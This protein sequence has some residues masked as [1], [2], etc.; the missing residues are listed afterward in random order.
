MV[1]GLWE[2]MAKD[3]AMPLPRSIVNTGHEWLLHLLDT[4]GEGERLPLL[5]TLWRAWHVRNEVVHFKPAPPI[6]ASWRF[7]GSY[8]NSL[9][10][11][12]QHPLAD[13]A[14]GKMVVSYGR[15]SQLHSWKAAP[16]GRS[17][18]RWKPPPD[19]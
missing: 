7:L 10:C 11:I 19:G 5:M 13:V 15:G 2:A 14:K 3:W 4:Y 12:K 18:E 9:M 1:V 17:P 16:P 8:I 6:E